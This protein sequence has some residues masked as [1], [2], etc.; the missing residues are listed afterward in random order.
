MSK[1][2]LS[3]ALTEGL[4]QGAGPRI[5]VLRPD[6]DYDLSGFAASDVTIVHRF[7]PHV[8]DWEAAGY[9]VVEDCPEVD[10]AVVV[11]PKSK[12]L[13]RVMIA[14]AVAKAGC[15]F[16]DGSK[17]HGIDSL[18]KECRKRAGELP[19][20][21]KAHGRLFVLPKSDLFDDW[22]SAGPV[23]GP[24]GFK[25]QAGV[26]S[27]GGVDRGSALLAKALPKK[28]PARVADFGAGWGYLSRTILEREGV[29]S[30][31]LWEAEGLS[32]DCARLNTPDERAMFHWGDVTREVPKRTYDAIVMN[33]PFHTG[34]RADVGLGQAFILAAA[35]ALVP[36]GQLW[37]VANRHLPY[38]SL[39]GSAFIKVEELMGDKGFKVLHASRPKGDR[40]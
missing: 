19:S 16:V 23:A 1:S 15:V 27:E 4:D 22:K 18:Y 33:P 13:A 29:Q 38:E 7:R 17:D 10:L 12:T 5:A 28:L 11:I 26:F 34:R 8:M 3:T 40:T 37:M 24:E 25:T 14:E 39:L 20:V 9:S 21:T 2:R 31:D 36:N 6:P 35:R 32:L 30:L